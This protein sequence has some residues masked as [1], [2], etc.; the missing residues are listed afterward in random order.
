MPAKYIRR[1][2]STFFIHMEIRPHDYINFV[3][4]SHV[5]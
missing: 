2:N 3:K 5:F 1:L 4:K